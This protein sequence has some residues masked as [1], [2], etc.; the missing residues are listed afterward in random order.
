MSGRNGRLPTKCW[1]TKIETHSIEWFEENVVKTAYFCD[2]AKNY[3]RRCSTPSKERRL[4]NTPEV[5]A[6]TLRGT[7]QGMT[8]YVGNK[9]ADLEME[10]PLRI[11][12]G[13]IQSMMT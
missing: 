12:G 7:G 3:H 1:P 8:P 2:S 11:G 9:I 10:I 4:S 5:L 6:H 13:L